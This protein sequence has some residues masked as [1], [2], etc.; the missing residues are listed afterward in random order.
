M[1]KIE[2]CESMQHFDV[3]SVLFKYRHTLIAEIPISSDKNYFC[4]PK[5]KLC[6]KK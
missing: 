5:A 4:K 6:Q 2:F 3:S 1:E